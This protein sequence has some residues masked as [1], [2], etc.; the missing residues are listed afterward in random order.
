VNGGSWLQRRLTGEKPSGP[1]FYFALVH[2]SNLKSN[3]FP[4]DS[5]SEDFCAREIGA[6]TLDTDDEG[7]SSDEGA[8]SAVSPPSPNQSLRELLSSKFNARYKDPTDTHKK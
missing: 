3:S 2:P 5:D 8:S 6:A 4:D 7:S 1:Q